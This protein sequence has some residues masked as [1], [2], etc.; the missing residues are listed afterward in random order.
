MMKNPEF[1][2]KITSMVFADYKNYTDNL[3]ERERSLLSFL[4][5]NFG[6]GEWNYKS[7]YM[8]RVYDNIIEVDGGFTLDLTNV[9]IRYNPLVQS[10][11]V[12]EVYSNG[13]VSNLRIM[14]INIGHPQG[15][16]IV[17]FMQSVERFIVDAL[18][19]I[20]TNKVGSLTRSIQEP[21]HLKAYSPV[22]P[23]TI[24]EATAE[25]SEIA[26]EFCQHCEYENEVKFTGKF[27]IVCS[28]CGERIMLCDRCAYLHS[29]N[30]EGACDWEENKG[31][32]R[33]RKERGEE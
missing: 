15:M 29:E 26:V 14:P 33:R 28:E 2:S 13:V 12:A 8:W 25:D 9:F 6:V 27:E 21:E 1:S 20:A 17:S 4:G 3:V 31:C 32:W 23:D 7:F 22:K 11:S 19:A 10:V 18:Y 30:N 24:A 5:K 16:S